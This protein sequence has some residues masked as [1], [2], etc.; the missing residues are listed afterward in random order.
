MNKFAK[1][2]TIV[3]IVLS[4]LFLIGT[5]ICL[6]QPEGLGYAILNVY[7]DVTEDF[8]RTYAEVY[9]TLLFWMVFGLAISFLLTLM[10]VFCYIYIKTSEAD[11]KKF[12]KNKYIRK[13]EKFIID[14]LSAVSGTR[15][16]Y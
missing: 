2:L 8:G 15:E 9:D 6:A 3:S 16:P 1:V 10:C 12:S 7:E 4:V 11:E 13:L 5:I 14:H